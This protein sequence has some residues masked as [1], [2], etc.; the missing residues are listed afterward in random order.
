MDVVD[1]RKYYNHMGDVAAEAIKQSGVRKIV[2]LSSLGA[3]L[4]AGTGPVIGLHDVEARLETLV[5]TDIAILRP[6]Y[7]MENFLM[8]AS[9]IKNQ[10]I[11]GNT[12]PA[13]ALVSLIASRDIAQKAAELLVSLSFSGHTIVELFGDRMSYKELTRILGEALGKPDLPYVQFP[14]EEAIKS[15]TSMGLSTDM[16]EGF[17]ELAAAIGKGMIHPTHIN[18]FK[19]NTATTFKKFAE[20]VFE[21][22]FQ[23]TI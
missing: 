13:D 1:V 21:P 14:E 23:K 11:N 19:P 22:V 20:K 7:F 17:V 6:G 5:H 3:E 12:A 8:N 18:P 9:L 10:N 16:A 2:F 15:M 4:D